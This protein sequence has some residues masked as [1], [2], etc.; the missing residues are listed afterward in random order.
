MEP[1]DV[2][3]YALSTCGHCKNTKEFLNQCGINY[4]CVDVDTLTGEQRQQVLEEVKKVN[5]NCSFPTLVIGDKVIVG[6]RKDEIKE[7]LGI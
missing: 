4:D 5:P 3:L 6:F 2:K 7:T 1:C